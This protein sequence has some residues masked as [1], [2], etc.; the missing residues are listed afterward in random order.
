MGSL[1]KPDGKFSSLKVT[2]DL[3]EK[4]KNR[5]FQN[6][7]FCVRL[8]GS[9]ATS[10]HPSSASTF[11]SFG[12]FRLRFSFFWW[13]LF[14]CFSSACL[15]IYIIIFFFTFWPPGFNMF[16]VFIWLHDFIIWY[17]RLPSPGSIESWVC[18]MFLENCTRRRRQ[19][20]IAYKK[21]Q[22]QRF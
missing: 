6:K 19:K 8:P 9:L 4:K 12:L 1:R 7:K 22:V 11:I 17:L 3:S 18:L 15:Y 13:I 10:T 16:L 20:S 21:F 14:N 2:I 5:I